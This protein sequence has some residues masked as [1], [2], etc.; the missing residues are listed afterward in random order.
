MSQV[1]APRSGAGGPASSMSDIFISYAHEDREWVRR[2]AA[3]LEALGWSVWWDPV[4]PTGRSFR[5]VI[6]E[7]LREA[8]SV[9]VVWS[10]ESIQSDWVIE[11]AQD[12]KDRGVLF[13]VFRH[14]VPPPRGFRLV[15]GADLSQWVGEDRD[16]GFQNLVRDLAALIG[17]GR[18]GGTGQ[19]P[20]D[21]PGEKAEEGHKAAPEVAAACMPD[22]P[23]PVLVHIAP[24]EFLMGTS[25]ADAEQLGQSCEWAKEWL[26]RGYFKHEQ[27][28]HTVDLDS[29][30]IGKHPVTNA[31]YEV[32][33]RA[34]KRPAPEHWPGGKAPADLATHPVVGVTWYEAV[35][36]CA[37]L[38]V[39]LREVGILGSREVIRLPTE[40]EWEKAARGTDGRFYPWGREWDAAR[41][42]SR[43]G[44]RGGTT[45]VGQYSPAGDSPYGL[46]DM[47]GNVWEWCADF[48][49][50]DY[51]ADSPAKNP[52]GP[53]KGN[54]RVLRGG[55]WYYAAHDARCSYRD[56]YVPESR[57]DDIG[58]RVVAF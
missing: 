8:R 26:E 19:A 45:P 53:A 30:R 47:A 9:V 33:V 13:P 36:Y 3:R 44:A 6:D 32:F 52:K 17:P 58:F 43:D 29:Y 55:S 28:Q 37:W 20:A 54:S 25:E 50:P 11:E 34:R 42:N 24:G 49:A 2:L 10:A 14:R 22:F 1:L 31:E 5:Q 7:A 38:T 40:A 41:C 39:R 56:R 51:Y 12:G 21:L 35:A 18:S 4:I 23:A 48:Y 15:Q 46:A 16:S 27:P 57:Y